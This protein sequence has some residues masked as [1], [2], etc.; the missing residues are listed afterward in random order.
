MSTSQPTP[1][2]ETGPETWVPEAIAEQEEYI[3][4][5]SSCTGV[6]GLPHAYERF[7]AASGVYYNACTRCRVTQTREDYE[8]KSR[9]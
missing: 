2:E 7:A 3:R 9:R 6:L 4:R 8:R 1:E 5:I